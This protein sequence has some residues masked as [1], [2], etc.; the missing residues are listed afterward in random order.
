MC[1]KIFCLNSGIAFGLALG[2]HYAFC[3]EGDEEDVKHTVDQQQE[4]VMEALKKIFE[5]VE[6]Q[7]QLAMKLFKKM[8]TAAVDDVAQGEDPASDGGDDADSDQKN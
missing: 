2:V 3:K 6:R 8:K 5:M 7:L 1:Y 4:E